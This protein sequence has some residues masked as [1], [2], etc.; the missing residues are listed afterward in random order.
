MKLTIL[1]T[2]IARERHDTTWYAHQYMY[3]KR[4]FLFGLLCVCLSAHTRPNRASAES[5][6]GVGATHVPGM[7]RLL[8]RLEA[9]QFMLVWPEVGSVKWTA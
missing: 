8:L 5:L 6:T 7:L 2:H 9:L 3:V 4:K 1:L